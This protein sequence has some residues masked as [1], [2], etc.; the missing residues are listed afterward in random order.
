LGSRRPALDGL[1]ALAFLSVFLAHAEDVTM[2]G[3]L[4]VRCFFALSGFLICGILL[5]DERPA[6]ELLGSF[7]RR[8]A[9]RIF[10]VYYACLAAL[11]A[12]GAIE[13]ARPLLLYVANFTQYRVRDWYEYT[14][15]FWTLGVEEQYYLAFP[16]LLI[17]FRKRPAAAIAGALVVSK[18]FRIYFAVSDS[19]YWPTLLPQIAAENLLWGAL[20]AWWMRNRRTPS[21]GRLLAAGAALVAF[22]LITS[23][24]FGANT[25]L[26]RVADGTFDGIGWAAIVLGLWTAPAPSIVRRALEWRPLV[27]VGA[28][29]YCGYCVHYPILRAMYE[30]GPAWTWG[31]ALPLTL[32]AAAASWFL[33]ERPALRLSRAKGGKVDALDMPDDEPM[34][35]ETLVLYRREGE[36]TFA[37]ICSRGSRRGSKGGRYAVAT[38]VIAE[39]QPDEATMRSR[40]LWELWS[41]GS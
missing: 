2:A 6:R 4:G 34:P 32:A 1:R 18:A 11:W 14:G 40:K 27:L 24:R 39:R 33:I 20:A 7:Y 36:A 22:A 16:L 3:V 17:A 9:A 29:S 10:P 8:R 13:H 21:S 37:F 41:A 28:V 19:S 5:D 26:A 35:D 15:H 30:L 31:V 12:V 25:F 23:P 38:Y